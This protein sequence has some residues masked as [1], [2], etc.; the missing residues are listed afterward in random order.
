MCACMCTC[1]QAW[2]YNKNHAM[3]VTTKPVFAFTSGTLMLFYLNTR[4]EKKK[5][6]IHNQAIDNSYILP[7]VLDL[8]QR[9]CTD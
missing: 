9:R 4:K 8:P 7:L 1:I 6:T 2:F 3:Y 5:R